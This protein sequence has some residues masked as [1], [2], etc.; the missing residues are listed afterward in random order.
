[1]PV[2]YQLIYY[3]CPLNDFLYFIFSA[4]DQQFRNEHL[5]RLKN[6]YYDTLKK[7]LKYFHLNVELIYPRAAFDKDYKERLDYGLMMAIMVLPFILANEGDVPDLSK[8]ELTDIK[9]SDKQDNNFKERIIGVVDDY[10]KW[11]YL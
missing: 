8:V 1:M 4:T 7:F 2:D 11:G 10:L 6:L 3:G 5:E 9:L